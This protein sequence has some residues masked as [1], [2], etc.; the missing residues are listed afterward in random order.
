MVPSSVTRAIPLWSWHQACKRCL[1]MFGMAHMTWLTCL[2]DTN[3]SDS[4][5]FQSAPTR[6]TLVNLTVIG[7][8]YLISSFILS[9][10]LCQPV[11]FRFQFWLK[12]ALYGGCKTVKFL[13]SISYQC[14]KVL[15]YLMGNNVCIY[16]YLTIIGLCRKGHWINMKIVHEK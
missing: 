16:P 3:L 13:Y 7:K 14:N 1:T 8:K 10:I 4:Q 12:Y 9:S 15:R 11:S 2:L 5:S 6:N